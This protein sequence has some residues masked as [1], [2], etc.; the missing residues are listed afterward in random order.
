M[1]IS[2]VCTDGNV[3]VLCA[4]FHS[5]LDSILLPW[6]GRSK[7]CMSMEDSC[8]AMGISGIF[9]KNPCLGTLCLSCSLPAL[10]GCFQTPQRA[11]QSST[12]M[13]RNVLAALCGHPAETCSAFH[14]SDRDSNCSCISLLWG[15]ETCSLR[16]C[17][18][19]PQQANR[20]SCPQRQSHLGCGPG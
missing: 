4:L 19:I 9:L 18:C 10:L 11:F 7:D 12:T 17:P 14:F 13:V 1:V 16:I 5:R 15:S 6:L 3:L 8:I 20:S 2:V